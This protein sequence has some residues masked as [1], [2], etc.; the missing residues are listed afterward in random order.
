MKHISFKVNLCVCRVIGSWLSFRRL[1]E[2][3]SV[4]LHFFKSLTKRG[5]RF[6][7]TFRVQ[8]ALQRWFFIDFRS[9]FSFGC[10]MKK[11]VPRLRRGMT[12]IL[13]V[14]YFR[15]PSSSSRVP[16]L[17]SVSLCDMTCLE[18][19][20]EDWRLA[21]CTASHVS[22]QSPKFKVEGKMCFHCFPVSCFSWTMIVFPSKTWCSSTDF[23]KTRISLEDILR[24]MM[25]SVSFFSLTLTAFLTIHVRVFLSKE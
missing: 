22:L 4:P 1:F 13:F 5:V 9:C 19:P 20:A 15:Y 6:Q 24:M 2:N 14:H 21:G 8:K 17:S 23:A 12:V 3:E 18:I 10:R 7:V 11:K 16:L 25:H